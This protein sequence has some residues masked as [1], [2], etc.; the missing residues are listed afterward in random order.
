MNRPFSGNREEEEP[1][2]EASTEETTSDSADET[3]GMVPA[4]EAETTTAMGDCV[5]CHL[6][7]T[8]DQDYI[9]AAYGLVHSEPCSHQTHRT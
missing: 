4:D 2:A 3:V 8:S 5:I 9:Q 7:V 1:A 6:P